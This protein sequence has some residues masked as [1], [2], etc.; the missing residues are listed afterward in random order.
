MRAFHWVR[1]DDGSGNKSD[2][3]YQSSTTTEFALDSAARL[4]KSALATI[5]LLNLF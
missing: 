3:F 4:V 5:V 2:V 1:T